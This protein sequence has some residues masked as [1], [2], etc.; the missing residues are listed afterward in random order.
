MYVGI[1]RKHNSA[2]LAVHAALFVVSVLFGMTY[3]A[4]KI[5]M[6]EI[7]PAA[8]VMLRAWGT[9]G[10]L[11]LLLGVQREKRDLRLNK[12][13]LG[14]VILYSLLGVSINQICFLTGLS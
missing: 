6:R 4:G 14:L 10:L 13:D 1:P 8:L 11:F 5:A 12:H 9:A 7:T 2:P 3:V